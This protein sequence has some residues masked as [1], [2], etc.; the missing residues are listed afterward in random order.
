MRVVELDARVVAGARQ[1]FWL[2]PDDE[3]LVVEIG[4]GAQALS[5]ECCDLLIVDAYHDEMHV[6]GACHRRV[7]RCCF[8][9]VARAGCLVINF[10]NDDPKF[11]QYLQRL[12]RA[13]GGAVM[14]MPALYDPNIIASPSVARR[15]RST[16]ARCAN[17]RR[18]SR[19]ATGCRSRAMFRAARHEPLDGRSPGHPWG[20]MP[21]AGGDRLLWRADLRR[22]RLR[23]GAGDHPAR[24]RISCRSSSRCRSSR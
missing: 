22:D 10:M 4:D 23:L 16:G 21:A 3:R 19:R 14:T 18:S 24:A 12:E 15:P 11:D 5:P 2:P 8:P 20:L 1:H 17:G 9:R 7:L 6:P 13:F